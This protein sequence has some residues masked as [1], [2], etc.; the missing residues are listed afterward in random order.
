MQII[1]KISSSAILD[2][3]AIS[4]EMLFSAIVHS[5]YAPS[6]QEVWHRT[7]S[8]LQ[9]EATE[10]LWSLPDPHLRLVA[11]ADRTLPSWHSML[12]CRGILE[13][14]SST[15]IEF[16]RDHRH[17]SPWAVM[18]N[19]GEAFFFE[20]SPSG[21]FEFQIENYDLKTRTKFTRT[22]KTNRTLLLPGQIIRFNSKLLHKAEQLSVERYNHTFRHIKPKYIPKI[23]T[24][25]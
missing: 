6:R 23:T 18:L 9:S 19:L 10:K 4:R 15:S 12:S 2:A 22:F 17:F 11:L 24:I 1:G 16:H 3:Y 14:G 8:N 20:E 5:T 7:A 13:N 21:K 25:I